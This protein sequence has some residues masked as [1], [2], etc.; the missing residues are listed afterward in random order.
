MKDSRVLIQK[1]DRARVRLTGTSVEEDTAP[2]P[3]GGDKE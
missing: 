2:C 1:G 3:T